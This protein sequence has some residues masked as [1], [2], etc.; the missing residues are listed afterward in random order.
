MNGDIKQNWHDTNVRTSTDR[1]VLEIIKK[2]KRKTALQ[3]LARR[4]RWFSNAGL[5][6][7]AI[8]TPALSRPEMIPDLPGKWLVLS[9]YALF[10][11][12]ASAM[13][14]WLY[15]GIKSID[16]FTMPVADVVSKTLFYR[17]RHLQF[18]IILIPL[19]FI[20]VGALAYICRNE[21]FIKG[22][23]I[24]GVVGFAVGVCQFLKFMADYRTVISE[25]NDRD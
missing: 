4:Y 10:L 21:F 5:L 17:K 15:Y 6:S 20:E 14:R 25:S 12:I 9:G 13:D 24:G 3:S 23:V 2:G 11:I 18:M 1:T 16:V 8:F 7:A 22:M 19:A